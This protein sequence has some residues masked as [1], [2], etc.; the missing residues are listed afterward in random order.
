MI[1]VI[2]ELTAAPQRRQEYLDIAAA[3]SAHRADA[4]ADSRKVRG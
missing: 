4:T 2:F 1:G 3:L